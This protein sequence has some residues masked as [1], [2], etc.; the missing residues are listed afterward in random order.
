MTGDKAYVASR[1]CT[2]AKRHYIRNQQVTVLTLLKA[3]LVSVVQVPTMSNVRHCQLVFA[4]VV[5]A[6][7]SILYYNQ[8]IFYQVS[9]HIN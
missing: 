7:I 2:F 9:F 8:T 6:L 5:L 3:E 1:V 4:V